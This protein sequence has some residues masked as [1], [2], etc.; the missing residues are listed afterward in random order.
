MAAAH[1][2]KFAAPWNEEKKRIQLGRRPA[3]PIAE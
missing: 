3:L 1:N 2:A